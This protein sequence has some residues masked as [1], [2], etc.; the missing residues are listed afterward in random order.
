MSRQKLIEAVDNGDVP[1][2]RKLL[3]VGAGRERDDPRLLIVRMLMEA[4][5][6]R[7]RVSVVDVSKLMPNTKSYGDTPL[8]HAAA[9]EDVAAAQVLLQCG[10]DPA[11][12]AL[13]G[14]SE[15]PTDIY[16][17]ALHRTA[18]NGNVE[19]ARLL[20]AGGADV[21]ARGMGGITPIQ[22]ARGRHHDDVAAVLKDAGAEEAWC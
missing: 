6:D 2:V 15:T 5:T 16:C 19:I 13:V 20:I 12:V 3:D 7:N 8:N 14:S 1:T 22:I 10:A 17:T 11:G 18:E 4:G 21:N 9:W